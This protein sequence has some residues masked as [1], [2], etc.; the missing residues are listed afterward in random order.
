MYNNDEFCINY[1][2]LYLLN[3]NF[4]IIFETIIKFKYLKLNGK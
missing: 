3:L 1:N 4:Y 2:N